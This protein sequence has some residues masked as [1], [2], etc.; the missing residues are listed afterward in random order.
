MRDRVAAYLAHEEHVVKQSVRAES[1]RGL[2]Y[3]VFYSDRAGTQ[4]V[5]GVAKRW[6]SG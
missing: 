5:Q 2:H 1:L 4:R 6:R 3:L